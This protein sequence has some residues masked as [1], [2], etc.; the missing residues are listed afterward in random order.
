[1]TPFELY[2]QTQNLFRHQ[3]RRFFVR[4]AKEYKKIGLIQH[5]WSDQVG[6]GNCYQVAWAKK[7]RGPAKTGQGFYF[8][9]WKLSE[10]TYFGVSQV[11]RGSLP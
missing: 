2:E 9:F 6:L 8:R 10:T 7:N 3:Q 11:I 4:M 5:A 1:M